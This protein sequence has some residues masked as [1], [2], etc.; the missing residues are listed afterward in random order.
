MDKLRTSLGHDAEKI[1][2]AIHDDLQ[3]LENKAK[4]F[5]SPSTSPTPPSTQPASNTNEGQTDEDEEEGWAS[6]R[7]G[8]G[9]ST[10]G[11][12]SQV[13][14]DLRRRSKS[15][16]TKPA[17]PKLGSA[18]PGRKRRRGSIR[19]GLLGTA[20][21]LMH[22]HNPERPDS[23][24]ITIEDYE[25]RGRTSGSIDFGA[26]GSGGS[27]RHSRIDSI[28]A[29]YPPSPR[30]ASPARSIRFADDAPRSPRAAEGALEEDLESPRTHVAFDLPPG[31]SSA[32]VKR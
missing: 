1:G 16:K 9:A 15:P 21:Q 19:R 4:V 22:P 14:A 11:S 32:G 3:V 23:P 30:S 6:D 29:S 24:S 18:P 27:K 20:Q 31:G 17:A 7:S 10:S 26:S 12:T 8:G 2:A 5:A 25:E 13:A 28:R